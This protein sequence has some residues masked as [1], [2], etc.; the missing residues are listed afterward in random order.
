MKISFKTRFNKAERQELLE[1]SQ[2][3][4]WSKNGEVAL[5]YLM[6]K[7][8][9]TA[10]VVRRFDV[11]F[12]PVELGS[13]YPLLGRLIFPIYDPSDN[14][15]AISSRRIIDVSDGLQA[16]WHESYEKSFYLYGLHFAKSYLRKWGFATVVE[17]QFDVLQLQCNGLYNAVGLLGTKMSDVQLSMAYRYCDKAVLILD[18][19]EN[20][21][22]QSGA[23]K[24]I[25]ASKKNAI[26]HHGGIEAVYL[27]HGD[28]DEYVRSH[29][30]EALKSLIYDV[31][32]EV[33]HVGT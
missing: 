21:A 14:L 32:T 4:L 15:I 13:S 24:I 10:E 31:V 6:D 8:C 16:Y 2:E 7:R 22:G 30:I 11:G 12:L 27:D 1:V 28:P 20:L 19:D 33:E 29:G 25:S 18:S 5:K 3:S 23:E 9:L 26:A 17:G